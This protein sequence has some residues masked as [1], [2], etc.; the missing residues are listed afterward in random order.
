MDE[1]EILI[2]FFFLKRRKMK[3]AMKRKYWVH[4]ML[5][6]RIPLGLCQSYIEEL[7]SDDGKF[8]EYLRMTVTTFDSLLVRLADNLRREN[9]H[10]RN[11]ISAEER[12]VITLRYLASGCSFKQLHYNFR[13]GMSTIS[14]IIKETCSVIWSVLSAEYLK[15]PNTE[16]EWRAI[17][18]AFKTKANFP[19]CLGALDGKH[20][21]ITKPINSGSMFFNYKDYFS[22]ILFAIVDSEYRFIYVSIGSY[23]KEC[24]SSILKQS[25]FWKKLNDGTLNIPRP[26]PLHEN[27]QEEI[28]YVFVGDE[29]FT[30]SQNLLRPYGGTHLDNKKKIF[31]YRLS[32]ARRYVE[33]TFGILSNKWRILHRPLDV[34]AETAIEV[35]KACTVLHNFLIK[36]DAIYLENTPTVMPLVNMPATQLRPNE[37]GGNA[38]RLQFSDYFVSEIGSVPWQNIT[39]HVS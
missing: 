31:N 10:F 21:R 5:M 29:A 16:E 6:K 27:M 34:C 33:C 25:N 36:K 35:V 3:R 26:T 2:M 37:G 12:L 11:C 39:A 19:H 4:P 28:P 20:I 14:K 32:R 17:A 23:G 9:T 30:L 22:F 7:K 1:D 15:L 8:Y 13:V 38:V 24:D 18:E